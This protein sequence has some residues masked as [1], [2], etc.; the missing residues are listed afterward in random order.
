[1]LAGKILGLCAAQEAATL[2]FFQWFGYLIFN[3]FVCGDLLPPLLNYLM[4]LLVFARPGPSLDRVLLVLVL[5]LVWDI[6]GC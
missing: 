1:V 2:W 5:E 6:S 4:L 3:C